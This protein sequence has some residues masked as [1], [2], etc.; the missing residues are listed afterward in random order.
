MDIGMLLMLGGGLG[1]FLYGMKMMGEGLEKLAGDRL[2]SLLEILTNNRFLGVFV[3]AVVTMIIQSSSATTVMVVGFVNAGLMT[4]AQATGVIMG[5]N[6]GTTITA[7][8][9]AFKLTAVAP[10]AILIGVVLILFAK[11]KSIQRLGEIV[12]GFG[13]LFMGMEL[14]SDA[15][16]PLREVKAFQDFMVSFK[17]PIVGVLVGLMVTA[18]IQSSSASVGIL[19]ALAMQNLIGLDAAV[20]VLFGQNIGTCVTALL[21]SI[22]TSVTARR[23]AVIHLMFNVIGTVVFLIVL[24]LPFIPFIEFIKSLSPND[25]VRQ[26]ANAHTGFNIVVT[27]LLFPLSNQLVALSKKI[28]PGKDKAVEERRLHFLDERILETPPIAVAQLQKEIKR[29]GELAKANL[30][31]AMDAFFTEDEAKAQEVLEREEIINFL[32]HEITNYLVKMNGLKLPAEDLRLVSSL[33]HVLSDIERVGDH[34]EN[35]V[36]YAL[37]RIENKLVFSEV[38]DNELRGM[39]DKVSQLFADSLQALYKQDKEIAKTVEPREQEIDA[40]QKELRSSHIERLN[41]QQCS[42]SSG[43]LFLDIVNNLERVADHASNIAYSVLD[44]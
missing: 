39:K 22:G 36:E 24:Q 43:M 6:I 1:L 26:I 21:A 44:N 9:I 34:A 25:T 16:E 27:A 5:A 20:Y 19:Q 12:A 2:R 17:N 42:P 8:L 29:M 11:K 35:L 14:M 15:M 7:Q 37:Y 32:N 40:L 18:I 23:A 3:G 4:L 10:L 41:K 33:F 38:A 13:I 28:I 30:E 31:L